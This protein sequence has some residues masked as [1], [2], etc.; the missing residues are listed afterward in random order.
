M[1]QAVIL[2]S[3]GFDRKIRFWDASNAACVRALRFQ[4][5][6]INCLQISSDK[7]LIAAGGNPKINL[8]DVNSRDDSPILSFDGHTGNVTELGFQKDCKWL[9]SCSEDGTIKIWDLRI[10]AHQRNYECLFPVNSV[11]LHPNQ[12]ELI[13]GDQNGCM[14]IWDLNAGA[15]RA[16]IIPA[17]ELPLRS[18]SIVSNSN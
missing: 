15:C 11:V 10:Q 14:N 7:H 8:Y 13:S 1:S 4:D 16:E 3:G 5:S 18:I 6:Q 12:A 17:P 9:Y 2:I